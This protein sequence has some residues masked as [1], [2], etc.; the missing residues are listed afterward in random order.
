[1][2]AP[3][4]RE[5]TRKAVQALAMRRQTVRRLVD[6]FRN[7]S[8]RLRQLKEGPQGSVTNPSLRLAHDNHLRELRTQLETLGHRKI[9]RLL[10]DWH[11]H[12]MVARATRGS[13]GSRQRTLQAREISGEINRAIEEIK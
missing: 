4:R 1:M 8:S 9:A 11:E 3:T 12:L 2:S 7:T 13:E 6:Q 5:R 10:G